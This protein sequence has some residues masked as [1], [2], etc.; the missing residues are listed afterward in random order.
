MEI[1]GTPW[2]ERQRLLQTVI[3]SPQNPS[4]LPGYR[5]AGQALADLLWNAPGFGG[6]GGL[7]AARNG[8]SNVQVLAR[9][10]YTYDRW[11]PRATL[12]GT[13]PRPREPIRVIAFAGENEGPAWVEA[14]RAGAV[15]FGGERATV[16]TVPLHGHLDVL[17]G[18]L[19]AEEVYEPT[20]R[21]I[22]SP[23]D[24]APAQR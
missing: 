14:V 24:A 9:L 4:P 15:A 6:P 2:E 17:A 16:R 7:S 5:T 23:G 10:L 11:W 22:M 8:V 19:S 1:G 21:W 13:P 20:R 12:G 18:R 3:A